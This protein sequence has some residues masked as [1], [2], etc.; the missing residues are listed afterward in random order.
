MSEV[1]DRPKEGK[2]VTMEFQDA[3]VRTRK[4]RELL[5]QMKEVSAA[6]G[7]SDLVDDCMVANTELQDLLSE[8]TFNP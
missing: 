7:R 1:L 6:M 5:L 8:L 2:L 4:A 3:Y